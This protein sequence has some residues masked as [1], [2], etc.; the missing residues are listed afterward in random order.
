MPRGIYQHKKGY[1]YSE[2]TKKK[3]REIHRRNGTG[4]WMKDK[5]H[6]EATKKKMSRNSP[7]YWLG[8]YR[9]EATKEKLRQVN[10]GKKQTDEAKEK[11]RQAHLGKKYA[12]G[13]KRSEQ[14]KEK[15]RQAH[16]DGRLK[17]IPKKYQF[18]KGKLHPYWNEGSSFEP[19]GLEFNEDLKEV[20]RNRDR[21]KCQ[22]CEKTE[23][24]NKAKLTIHHIDYNKQNNDPKNL[25]SLCHQC[26]SKT[27]HKRQ[28]WFNYFTN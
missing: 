22:N 10:L 14:F 15:L 4:K 11:N 6:S 3:M 21:R 16:K 28:Y 8:K 20:I 19:Y 2:D 26:H 1:K 23:L 27:N 13:C 9:S 7:K 5:K 24:E 18:S 12:K 17:P 25:I